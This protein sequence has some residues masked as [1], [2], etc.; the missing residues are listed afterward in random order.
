MR[1]LYYKEKGKFKRLSRNGL[2]F[3]TQPADGIWL[4]INKEYGRGMSCI[5]RL[6]DLPNA[7]DVADRIK[8]SLYKDKMASIIADTSKPRSANDIA[9]EII[10]LLANAKSK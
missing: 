8:L 3:P 10:V 4:V 2:E 7:S 1:Q 6:T 9:E 5:V